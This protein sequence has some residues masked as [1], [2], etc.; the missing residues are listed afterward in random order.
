MCM[1]PSGD[2]R[3]PPHHKAC[4]W[5]WRWHRRASL[6]ADGRHHE[7]VGRDNGFAASDAA[8]S[9]AL[10]RDA[11]EHQQSRSR[12]RY[13]YVIVAVRLRDHLR[14][15]TARYEPI[16]ELN[17]LSAREPNELANRERGEP[18]RIARDR[19]EA[20]QVERLVDEPRTLAVELVRKS[21]GSQ[22]HDAEICG[23]RLD[24]AA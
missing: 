24:R 12:V 17:A 10:R 9:D 19:I 16:D 7:K 13:R 15:G 22:Y 21:A 18:L 3:R 23:A 2:A 5:R 4:I 14:Q 11:L 20:H 1:I 6:L 8:S